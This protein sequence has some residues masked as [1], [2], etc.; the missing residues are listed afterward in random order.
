MDAA[1]LVAMQDGALRAVEQLQLAA[2]LTVSGD[3]V[4]VVNHTGHKLISGYP[5]GRRMWLR[6]EWFDEF[7]N[8]LRSDGAYGEL[9]VDLDGDHSPETAVR[10]II[11]LKGANTKIYEAHYGMTQAWAYQLDPNCTSTKPLSFNRVTGEV[12]MTLGELAC[13]PDG[14]AHESFHFVLNDTIIKDNRIPPFGM[15]YDVARVRNA[16]PVPADQYGGGAPGSTYN[17]WDEITLDPP[18]NAVSANIEL[19]YQPTSWEYIQ[20]LYLANDGQNAFLAEEGVN[21]LDAWLNTGMAEPAVMASATWG[22]ATGGCNAQIP[23]LSSATPSDKAVQVDWDPVSGDPDLAGFKLY[24]DQAGK[25]QLVADLACSAGDQSTCTTHT[26]TGLTNGQEYCYKVTSYQ[27]ACESDFS[28]ILC[29][30]PVQPGQ[31]ATVPDVVGLVQ[32]D[33]EAAIIAADL[34]VGTVTTEHSDSVAAGYVISQN[35]SG[36]TLVPSG[37]SVDLVVS[38]GPQSSATLIVD[39]LTANDKQGKDFIPQSTFNPGDTV[40][41][42]A[43][44]S[45]ASNASPIANASVNLEIHDSSGGLVDTLQSNTDGSGVATLSWKVPRKNFPSGSYLAVVVSVTSDGYVAD[46]AQSVTTVSLTIQ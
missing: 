44:V 21:M 27:A 5:E 11:D 12:E 42:L 45:D 9:L 3:T 31:Q 30:T 2:T 40:W 18:L 39:S 46:L 41:L 19:L 13:S 37:S 6:I 26:D 35:P 10:T 29:A 17:Y 34:A 43:S 16:L 23:I 38:L 22:S 32:A 24:Y 15:S 14:T 1:Q 4:K 8:T 25:A 7:G 36:G 28:N 33:A 20:F